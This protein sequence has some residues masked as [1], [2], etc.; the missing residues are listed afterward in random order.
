MFPEELIKKGINLYD[1]TLTNELITEENLKI[2]LFEKKNIRDELIPL[3]NYHFLHK[4]EENYIL[5]HT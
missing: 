1:N 3:F 4:K 2:K 5:I